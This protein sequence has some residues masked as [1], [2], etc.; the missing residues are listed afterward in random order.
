MV[1]KDQKKPEVFTMAEKVGIKKEMIEAMQEIM[2]AYKDSSPK[3]FGIDEL[4]FMFYQG[5]NAA[6]V[7]DNPSIKS[8]FTLCK[9]FIHGYLVGRAITGE[10]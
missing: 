4:Y 1:V 7:H 5:M 3:A 6:N 2:D 9:I 8:A 10:E